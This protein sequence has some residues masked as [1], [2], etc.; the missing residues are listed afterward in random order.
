MR[1]IKAARSA[2]R[3]EDRHAGLAMAGLVPA[4]HA[5]GQG[6]DPQDGRG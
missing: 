4:I 1:R 2:L 6:V 5:D 3:S